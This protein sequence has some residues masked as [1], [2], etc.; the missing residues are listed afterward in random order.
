MLT[1]N[2]SIKT[3]NKLI[4]KLKNLNYLKGATELSMPVYQ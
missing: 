1:C 2:L 3:C 4:A